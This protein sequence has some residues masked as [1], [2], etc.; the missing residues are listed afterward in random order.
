MVLHMM[1]PQGTLM[2]QNPRYQGVRVGAFT[3]G[4]PEL[5]FWSDACSIGKF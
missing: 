1:Q 5:L 2:S 3:Y 4:V